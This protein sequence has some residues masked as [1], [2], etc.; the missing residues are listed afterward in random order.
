M[1]CETL[2]PFAHGLVATG[3]RPAPG[4]VVGNHVVAFDVDARLRYPN[5][6]IIVVG[7]H[8]AW[9]GVQASRGG[10]RHR[11]LHPRSAAPIR[12]PVLEEVQLAWA[13]QIGGGYV[14]LP[15]GVPLR[16]ESKAV[17]DLCAGQMLSR[18]GLPLAIFEDCEADST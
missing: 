6:R 8:S 4:I 16:I 5:V 12:G 2:S 14:A 11:K 13:E 7:Q 10:L 15:G 18:G 17:H 1:R 3:L 9:L